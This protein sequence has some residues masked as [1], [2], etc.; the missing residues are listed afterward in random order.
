MHGKQVVVIVDVS[1]CSFNSLLFWFGC[2]HSYRKLT[3]SNVFLCS[4]QEL[5]FRSSSKYKSIKLTNWTQFNTKSLF[6]NNWLIR[7][8]FKF[9]SLNI[10]TELSFVVG[11]D[12]LVVDDEDVVGE[13]GDSEDAVGMNDVSNGRLLLF[14]FGIIIVALFIFKFVLFIAFWF[15]SV[16]AVFSYIKL[17]LIKLSLKLLLKISLDNTHQID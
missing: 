8:S 12:E 6:L 9:R 4:S 11:L 2:F 7:F 17:F 1:V 3:E 14:W 13:C 16:C 15:Q 5:L 10:E